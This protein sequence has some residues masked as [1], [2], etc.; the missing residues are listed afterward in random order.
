MTARAQAAAQ[1]VESAGWTD[2]TIAPLSGDASF[3]R[4][5]RVSAGSRQAILMD[6]PPDR[7]DVSPFLHIAAALHALEY[8]APEIFAA[9]PVQGL[10]LLEDLGDDL[11]NV[12]L[13]R[14]PTEMALY[15]AAVDLLRDLHG[16]PVPDGVPD[17]DPARALREVR[18]FCEWTLPALTGAVPSADVTEMFV[19]LWQRALEPM[20]DAPRVLCLFDYHAE[21]LIWLPQRAGLRRVGL[22]D[23]QD[24]VRGP[25]AYDLVSLLEDARRDVSSETV[26]RALARYLE[27][28]TVEAREAFMASYALV[29]A[30]RNTRIL[31]VFGR[32]FLRDDKAGYLA[33]M[34]RVWRHLENDLRAPE[35][36]DL[37]DWFD[38]NVPAEKRRT[39]PSPQNFV[40]P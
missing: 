32:L 14:E 6:A 3:R 12:V 33:L 23:F 30:Q 39:T 2:A 27:G 7:E 20:F 5:F 16:R 40:A 36:A 35:L 11:F 28:T 24:A 25:A 34:P 17:F 38:R 22:L 31:G 18:L 21:N 8:S 37:R 1:F 10:L 9:D 19:T 13:A 26:D 15:D 29:G 4:Y